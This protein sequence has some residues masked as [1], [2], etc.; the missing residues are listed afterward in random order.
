M[1]KPI[2]EYKDEK[3]Y[4]I[5]ITRKGKRN[6]SLKYIDCPKGRK[7][8]IGSKFSW[9]RDDFYKWWRLSCQCDVRDRE[10][11]GCKCHEV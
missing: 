10:L 11:K 2:Y 5:I 3:E 4:K 1:S 7:W 9:S 6:F 8:M